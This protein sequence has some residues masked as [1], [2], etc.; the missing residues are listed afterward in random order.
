MRDFEDIQTKPSYAELLVQCALDAVLE[1][2]GRVAGKTLSPSNLNCPRSAAF[3]LNGDLAREENETYQSSMLRDVG[4][5]IHERTQRFLSASNIWVNVEDFVKTHPELGIEIA[6]EQKHKG[7]TSLYFSGMRNGVTVS[8]PFTF[9]CDGIVYIDG[10]YYI[11]EIKTESQKALQARTGPNPKYKKQAL[12]YSFLYNTSNILWIY[13]SRESYGAER[14]IYLQTAKSVDIANFVNYCNDIG[15][16]VEN[17][18][19][20]SL[21]KCKDCRYCAYTELCKKL[22]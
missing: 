4:S 9:Q 21:P 12:A 16:A 15:K 6:K 20:K 18:D 5:F 22:D 14:K 2:E 8:P 11:I 19:I 17:N 1:T 13:A 10:Q 3:K 7:E